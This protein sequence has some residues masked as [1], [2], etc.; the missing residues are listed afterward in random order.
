MP[1]APSEIPLFPLNTVLFPGSRLP[2]KVFEARYMDMVRGCM[3][4]STAFGVCLIAEGVEVGAP[5]IPHEVG[6]SAHIVEWDMAQLGVLHVAARGDRRFRIL[7]R[8]IQPDGLIRAVVKWLDEPLST[9]I[10][11]QFADIVPLLRAVV[12]D[13]GEE[14][15]PGPHDFSNANWIGYRYA[16]ILPIPLKA[17]QK[18]LELSDPLL[19]LSILREFLLQRDLL[20][21]AS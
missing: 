20:K 6:T 19:R 5:A 8:A 13:A 15:M 16:E 11:Q 7:H 2:L 12:S 18:L 4:E 21:P 10:P 14:A 3:R 9:E 17:K 1:L